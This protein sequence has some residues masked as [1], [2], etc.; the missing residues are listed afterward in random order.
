[1]STQQPVQTHTTAFF[2]SALLFLAITA[3]WNLI[4]VWLLDVSVQ[5][6]WTMGMSILCAM[7]AVVVVSKV[8]RDREEANRPPAG[9]YDRL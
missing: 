3:V 7:F 2:G 1:M 9:Q 6:R 4:N 8:V 5:Q